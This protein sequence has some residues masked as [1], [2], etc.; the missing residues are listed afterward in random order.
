MEKLESVTQP[1]DPTAG[2]D[3][4]G[5]SFEAGTN[6]GTVYS[7]V[8]R[9]AGAGAG[10]IS[11]TGE[12]T[13]R[14]EGVDLDDSAGATTIA[15]DLGDVFLNGTKYRQRRWCSGRREYGLHCWWQSYD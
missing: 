2:D 11:I 5:I 12:A 13:N 9:T 14:G 4:D 7:T 3:N 6:N 10:N 1:I 15:T 8:I